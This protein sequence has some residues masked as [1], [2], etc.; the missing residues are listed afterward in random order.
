MNCPLC[1]KY[2][3]KSKVISFCQNDNNDHDF[4]YTED[5]CWYL[6]Y[7]KI[8]IGYAKIPIHFYIIFNSKTILIPAFKV[9]ES[10]DILCKYANLLAFS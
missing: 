5:H 6:K 7:N 10:F 2:L 8:Q 9:E 4:I 1:K 3:I